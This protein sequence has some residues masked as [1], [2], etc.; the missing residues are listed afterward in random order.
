MERMDA[1]IFDV[2]VTS[3]PYNI[4]KAYSA[5]RDNRERRDYLDWMRR[6]AEAASRVLKENGSF[7]LNVGGKPSDPWLPI[8]VASE[9]RR[10]LTLQNVIHWIKHISI[11][12]ENQ[13]SSGSMNGD[14][15]FGHFKPINSEQYLNQAQEHIFHFTKAGKTKLDKLA[16]GVPYQDKSNINRWSRK[17][18]RRDRG[19]VWFIPYETKVGSA[20]NPMLHP[21]EFPV[22]LPYLCI[23]LHGI[24]DDTV[25]Y[26]PFMGIGSTAVACSTLGVR[27][28]GTEIDR[29][30]IEIAGNRIAQVSG[31]GS[32]GD[33]Q[34]EV[35][36][37]Q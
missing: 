33:T 11:P 21:A 34:Q 29:N 23:K 15:S 14:V 7:F 10:F 18:D 28:V 2:I 36:M 24:Q 3:P 1:E 12:G 20:K 37:N 22:K 35:D 4:N 32:S 13:A 17:E 27:Y 9:F 26:D 30:Y 5:Y 25:V 31:R 8:D 16:I 6:V 19:N